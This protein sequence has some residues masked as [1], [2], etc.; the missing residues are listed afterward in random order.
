VVLDDKLVAIVA[1]HELRGSREWTPD[2]VAALEVAADRV[3]T[4]LEG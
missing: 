3:R 2:D 4:Q 1:A